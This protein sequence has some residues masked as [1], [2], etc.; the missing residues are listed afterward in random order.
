MSGVKKFYM[1]FGNGESSLEAE[2]D[3]TL[4]LKNIKHEPKDQ[5]KD[6]AQEFALDETMEKLFGDIQILDVSGGMATIAMPLQVLKLLTKFS[7]L[8][9]VDE[10]EIG[11]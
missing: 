10:M 8:L 4:S 3:K 2:S 1:Q 5:I 11:R 7:E 6:E 9:K